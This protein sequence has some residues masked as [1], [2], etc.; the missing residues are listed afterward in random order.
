MINN[1]LFKNKGFTLVEVL[2]AATIFGIL[3]VAVTGLFI[4]T[5]RIEKNVLGSKKVLGQINYATEYMSRALRM[6]SKDKVGTCITSG[7]NYESVSI[8]EIKFINTLQNRNCQSF[9][10]N[11]NQIQYETSLGVIVAL[12]SPDITVEN[13]KFEVSGEVQGDSLQPF[14]TIYIEAHAEN[15][16]TLKVQTS[17][18]QRNLDINY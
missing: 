5:L 4:S 18:S 9:F 16:P 3:M 2:V 17:V 1:K 15:G 10:L 14:V 11:N 8:N 13:L 6:A 7:S 12:T